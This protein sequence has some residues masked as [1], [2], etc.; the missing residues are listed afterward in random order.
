MK[1]ILAALSSTDS[2]AK[3]H[4]VREVR[5]AKHGN[6]QTTPRNFL[7]SGGRRKAKH[8]KVAVKQTRAH[9]HSGAALSCGLGCF[10]TPCP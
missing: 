7:T 6:A 2:F 4:R 10:I 9:A 5:K 1:E 8:F 3:F